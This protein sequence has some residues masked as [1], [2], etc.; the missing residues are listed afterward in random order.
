MGLPSVAV[1]PLVV[2]LSFGTA[3][4][5]TAALH[6]PWWLKVLGLLFGLMI[7]GIWTLRNPGLSGGSG[8]LVAGV[9]VLVMMVVFVLLRWRRPFAWWEF[10]VLWAL[11]GAAMVIG[12]GGA[13]S[14]SA[15]ASSRPPSCCR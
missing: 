7:T 14:Q 5:V 3:A 12:V 15:S 8:W 1:G 11:V 13:G 2:L 6:G 9:M 4:A 10:A